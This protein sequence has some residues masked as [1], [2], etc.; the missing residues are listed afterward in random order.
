[1]A[2]IET[3]RAEGVRAEDMVPVRSRISWGAIF[4]GAVIALATFLVLT[5]FGGAIGLSISDNV[6]RD[7]LGTGA[8]TWAIVSMAIALFLGG[9]VTSQCT[10]G[11][12]KMEAVVHG[13]MMW[14]VVLA[15][16][17]WLAAMGTRAGF[18][19]MIGMTNVAQSTTN[20]TWEEMALRAGVSQTQIDQWR[21]SVADAPRAATDPENQRQ[22]A[23]AATQASWWTLGGTLLSIL[24]AVAG[25]VVGAGPAL[26][27]LNVVGTSYP[28][29]TV[30]GREP[31]LRP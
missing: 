9:M 5:L 8:A 1:M 23:N 6:E 16:L 29:T 14:G 20:L 13:I 24:A 22:A 21:R 30:V 25:A 28:H 18:S 31:A 27:L 4:A 12:N 2:E 17:L 10:V 15:M 7:T 19:A 3:I 11:E 26:R